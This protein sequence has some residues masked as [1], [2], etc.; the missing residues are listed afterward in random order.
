VVRSSDGYSFLRPFSRS[1]TGLH[2]HRFSN[3]VFLYSPFCLLSDRSFGTPSR[4][5]PH[6]KSWH[7]SAPSSS[8]EPIIRTFPFYSAGMESTPPPHLVRDISFDE[9][10]QLLSCPCQRC[11]CS[12]RWFS[13]ISSVNVRMGICREQPPS[14]SCQMQRSGIWRLYGLLPCRGLWFPS[15]LSYIFW[16]YT[17]KAH[18]HPPIFGVITWQLLR[19]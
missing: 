10:F 13:E 14:Y 18:Y 3:R 4:N 1:R 6:S 2:F 11:D 15:L 7:R 17:T 5:H 16:E 9:I 12:L 8:P 19:Q